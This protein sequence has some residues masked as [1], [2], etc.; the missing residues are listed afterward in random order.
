ML[1]E[2]IKLIIFDL[3]GTLVDTKKDISNAIN[4]ALRNIGLKEKDVETI[5][6]YV[7][8]GLKNTMF[9]ALDMKHEDLLDRS[10]ELFKGYYLKHLV[11]NALVYPGVLEFLKL[12][13]GIKKAVISNKDTDLCIETLKKLQLGKYFDIILGGDDPK[14]RKPDPCPLLKVMRTFNIEASSSLIIGDMDC[15]IIAGKAAKIRTCAVTYGFGKMQ[16][17]VKLSPDH[18]VNNF[19]DLAEKI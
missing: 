10:V 15:D 14:C 13:Y 16:D 7:G 3:D 5:T 8:E 17:I 2:K 4:Y 1:K 18:I 11:D 6:S 9:K 12:S 19:M